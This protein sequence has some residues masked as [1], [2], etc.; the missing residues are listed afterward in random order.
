[1]SRASGLCRIVSGGQTGVDRAALDAALRHGVPCGGWC[2]GDRW[3]ED[4]QI[5]DRYPLREADSADPAR[6]T[7]ANVRDSDATAIIATRPLTGGTRLTAEL[8]RRMGRPLCLL[9]A[10][11][12]DI[13]RMV[14]KLLAFLDEHAVSVLNV[15]GPRRSQAPALEGVAGA[16]I[17][18]VLERLGQADSR[19][20]DV[21]A[22]SDSMGAEQDVPRQR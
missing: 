4:G 18:G 8:A 10:G 2:P 11:A 3:A 5:P 1:M 13:E 6:R 9:D 22:A 17:G 21:S 20:L 19:R 16:V 7:E 14:D 15:A 12:A